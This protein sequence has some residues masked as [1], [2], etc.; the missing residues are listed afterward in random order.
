MLAL[1]TT[2]RCPAAAFL[3]G[4]EIVTESAGDPR[5]SHAEQLPGLLTRLLEQRAIQLQAVDVFAVAGGP[6]S[7]TGLRIGIAT[8]QALALVSGRPLVLVSALDALGRAGSVELPPDALVGAW[9]DARRRDVFSAL[10]RVTDHAPFTSERLSEVDGPRVGAPRETLSRWANGPGL[11]V[12][13]VGD[14]ARLYA[15][16]IGSDARV[17]ETPRLAPAIARLALAQVRAGQRPTPHAAQ[18]LYVRRPDAEIARDRRDG[19]ATGP[20]D[21]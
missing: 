20:S 1:D 15:P 11:P 12:V 3:D 14:G 10:Y 13:I 9:I 19:S 17:P 8:M 16:L 4:D 6:G 18:P 21:R 7:F 2:T 5:Q